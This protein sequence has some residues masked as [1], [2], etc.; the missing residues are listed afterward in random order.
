[1]VTGAALL[2]TVKVTNGSLHNPWTKSSCYRAKNPQHYVGRCEVSPAGK[3]VWGYKAKS[4]DID[5]END[6]QSS[7][8]AGRRHLDR[9]CRRRN[10]SY[11]GRKAAPSLCH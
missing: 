11:T 2:R 4:G 1:M 7:G 3:S 6:I 10:Y 9:M 5:H 8:G